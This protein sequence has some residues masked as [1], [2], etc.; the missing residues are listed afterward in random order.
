MTPMDLPTLRRRVEDDI[1]NYRY[2]YPTN[3]VG[4]AWT[5]ERVKAELA[6]LCAA[7]VDPYWADVEL[8]DKSER[9][10]TE[11]VVV[12]KCAFLA[13]RHGR[14]LVA[15]GVRGDSVGCFMSR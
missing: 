8:S 15:F 4:T 7:V 10:D 12:R 3:S 9:I 2:E 6:A 11:L 1:E 13:A 14:A 5:G